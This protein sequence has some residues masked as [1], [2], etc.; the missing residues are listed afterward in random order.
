MLLSLIVK[1][2][3]HKN[4][5]KQ[6]EMQIDVLH[7]ATR[8]AR[9]VKLQASLAIVTAISDLMRHLR[10]CLQCSIEASSQG[11][12]TNKLNSALHSAIE[13]CLLQLTSKVSF[14]S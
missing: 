3:D 8:L 13:E 2:L 11:N 10:K 6:P 12:D 1:H 5:A 9:N 4:V 14:S 7:I